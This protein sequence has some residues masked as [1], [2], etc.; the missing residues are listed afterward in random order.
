MAGIIDSTQ[1]DMA[2]E[3]ELRVLYLDV[4]R[5][6]ETLGLALTSE[7]S[8]LTPSDAPPTRLYVLIVPLPIGH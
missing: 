8:K 3:K 7:K 2:L 6:R 4:G 1:V 5:K